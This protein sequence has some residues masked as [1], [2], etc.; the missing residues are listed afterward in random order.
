MNN[1]KLWFMS[2]LG[3]ILTITFYPTASI[4]SKPLATIG[5]NEHPR[6]FFDAN[7]ILILQAKTATTHQEIWTPIRDYVD[8]QLG[9]TPPASAPPTGDLDTY[10]NYGN[11]LIPFALTCVITE[12]TDYCDL[13]KTYLL[14]YAT[15]RQWG[16]DN[17]REL[18]HA[19]ML[20]G[21][22]IAYDWL[23]DDLSPTE[24]QIVRQSLADWAQKMYEAST[25]PKEELWNNWWT[26]AYVQNHFLIIHSAL[27]MAGLA[28]LGEDERAQTWVDQASNQMSQAQYVLNGIED[29]SWHEGMNYQGYALTLALPFWVNLKK[30]QGIDN[31][32][33]DYLRNYPY[34]RLYNYL[35][36]STQFIMAYSDFEWSFGDNIPQNLLRFTAR[37]YCNGYAEWLAQQLIAVDGRHANV[38]S[39]PWYVFEFLYYEPN[40]F[41]RTP[42]DLEK[43][44]IFPDLE[45]IIWR[46]GWDDDDLVFGLKTGAYGG[47]FAFDTFTQEILP[48]EPPCDDTDCKLSF[49][50][51][52]DDSNGFYLY[53]AGQWLAP[54]TV[55]VGNYDTAF[56]NT[57]LIDD[58]GQYRP[59]LEDQKDPQAFRGS[60]GFLEA[61]ADT[62]N[63]DYVAA[64]ATGRYKDIP[65][66]QD[67][68]RHVVF[69]RPDYFLMLD[70]L[71]AND[72]HQYEWVSHFD[73][74]V[75]VEDDWVR[76]DAGGGQILGVGVAAPQPFETKSGDDGQPYIRI[77]PA[78]SL[79]N[80]RLIHILYPTDDD[81]WDTKPIVTT[82][83]DTGEAA[84]VRVQMDD[85]QG[86]IDDILLT[87]AEPVPEVTVGPYE[88]DGQV[89]VV[90]RR[91]DDSLE[92]LF[93][94]G[95]TFL[96]DRSLDK[97][98]VT[99]LNEN[100]SF[101]VTYTDQ[102]V[103]IYGNIVTEVTLYAPQA[104]YLT[105]NGIPWSF[106][107]F[108]D[109][110]TPEV[111]PLYLPTIIA[112][113]GC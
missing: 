72:A 31:L 83:D 9:T 90:S 84:V 62:P 112:E 86:R 34:W 65:D 110:I 23:Y 98:L 29:G 39:T 12:K 91:A 28:L 30:I 53:R 109:Y 40:S 105:V 75:T 8:S 66:L 56:H 51:N 1:K 70:N 108:D 85:G 87:Y 60:D 57:L 13:A 27:G 96:K 18:G 14:T 107:R 58:Q 42:T 68:T 71:V 43:T 80:A 76:G 2:M 15:W 49:G 63:F 50:H 11:Q 69:V 64:D 3:A 111:K 104:T 97:V 95:G 93:V 44:R 113:M 16:E 106:T 59:S 47:R 19:H 20:L 100:Q 35:P 54:E 25:G 74:S 24:R 94:Y 45:G 82:L 67:I 17:R 79:T 5:E 36:N 26:K 32:P 33:H 77:R 103:A 55:G 73:D 21:N 88:Y 99:N 22:A 52:H 61:T 92:K 6:L 37:E 101:E 89:A 4:N 7:E 46:T 81:A 78:S 10:R 102:S 48:W 38:W 41:L